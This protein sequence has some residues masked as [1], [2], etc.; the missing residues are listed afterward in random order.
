VP[1]HSAESNSRMAVNGSIRI[2]NS[3][4]CP[5]HPTATGTSRGITRSFVD[6]GDEWKLSHH[7]RYIHPYRTSDFFVPL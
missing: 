1:V 2:E 6:I 7:D 4:I 5:S 3:F